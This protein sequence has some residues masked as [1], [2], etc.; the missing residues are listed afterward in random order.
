MLT[1]GIRWRCPGLRNFSKIFDDT[2]TG[3]PFLDSLFFY[4]GGRYGLLQETVAVAVGLD[5]TG[6]ALFTG[7]GY[8]ML[9]TQYAF[10]PFIVN[11]FEDIFVIHFSRRRLIPAGDVADLE[12]GDL[13]VGEV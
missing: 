12:V 9:H 3:Y 11:M 5:Q 4:W 8:A 1:G 7:F 10:I 2:K 13:A 6:F